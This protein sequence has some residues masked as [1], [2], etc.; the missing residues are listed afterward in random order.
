[1][2][3]EAIGTIMT[4]TDI[5]K[6]NGLNVNKTLQSKN[7]RQRNKTRQHSSK[8]RDAVARGA[9]ERLTQRSE[10]G[11]AK[12][13]NVLVVGDSQLRPLKEEKVDND[14]RTAEIRFKSGMKIEE[15]KNKVG[16]SDNSDVIIVHSGTNN[17]NDKSPSD[18]AEVIVNSME[19][20]Q[21]K[22]PSARVE[23]S[24]IFKRKDDQTLNVKAR[25][26][27]ELLSE[28]LSIRDIDFINNDNIIYRNLWKD[29]LH[30]N[31]GGVRKFSG[32]LN[33]FIKY[34]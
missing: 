30:L 18:L 33:K 25:K 20:V 34:C 9:K 1:M 4:K 11:T 26:V 24:S 14:H 3:T 16:G 2:N 7:Y 10:R 32:N 21:K 15:V 31:E 19:S 8:P 13:L 5:A 12:K 23:Y 6:G 28:E 29:G 27:N 22:N 17:V